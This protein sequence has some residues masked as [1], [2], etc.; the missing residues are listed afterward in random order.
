MTKGDYF[1]TGNKK[2]MIAGKNL[3][4]LTA[5]R[6][7]SCSQEEIQEVIAKLRIKAEKE[8]KER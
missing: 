4:H 3:L 2:Y 7:R 6:M 5:G 1:K 8:K